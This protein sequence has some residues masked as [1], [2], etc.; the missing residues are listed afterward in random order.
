MSSNA[1][2]WVVILVL[3]IGLAVGI[4]LIVRKRRYVAEIRRRGWEWVERPDLGIAVGLNHPPFGIGFNRSVDDQV[5]G[6]STAGTPFQ[7]FRYR[8]DGFRSDG[9]VVTMPLP[10]PVPE[11]YAFSPDA[12][13]AGVTG[14]QVAQGPL[15][16]VTT[17]ATF[18]QAAAA[19]VLPVLGRPPA[20]PDGKPLRVDVGTDHDQL[21]LL[22]APRR[23]E[24]LARAVEWL[25]E[26]H[27][28]LVGS[29]A[30]Q[31][32][33]PAAPRYLS[34]HRL[35]H[36]RYIPRDDSMLRDVPHT[37]GG[38]GHRAED[39]IISDN[40]GLPF[41][42]L[43]HHWQTTHTRTDSKGNTQTYTQ[44]HQEVCC[45][46]RTTFPFRELS[47]N[48]GLF[49]GKVRFESAAFNDRFT[50]RS[51]IPRFASDVMHPRQLEHLLRTGPVPFSIEPDGRILVGKGDW[52]PDELAW[53]SRFLHGFFGRV[54]DFTWKELGAWPRPIPEVL[55]HNA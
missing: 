22:H 3:V 26:V 29:P 30:M 6:R 41:I 15:T 2:T 34:F 7:A 8:S 43:T 20:D 12:P 51:P 54:P 44:N 21:V 28:A 4:T 42:R 33:G 25:A 18:G 24:A 55:D 52:T 39:I 27:G 53:F 16:A 50:V 13:R 9:Y 37:R 47:V 31:T 46:F 38:H 5:I 32:T 19:A 17:H 14:E 1:W 11:F 23:P 49:G 48:W 36:W 40:A 45:Q 35:P 10:H